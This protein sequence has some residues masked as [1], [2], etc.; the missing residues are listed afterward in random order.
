MRRH[1][2]T[3]FGALLI[4]FVNGASGAGQEP[5]GLLT[6]ND[7]LHYAELNNAGLKSSFQRWQAAKEEIP[8]AKTLPDPQIS[9]NY[10]TKQSDLQ[11]KQTFSVMQPFPWFGKINAR[12]EAATKEAAAAQQNYQA[13]RLALFKE[14]KEGFYE[15]AYLAR[16]IDIATEN[17]E[18]FKHF[19]E[20]ART[21]HM[22]TETG[23]PDVIRAQVEIAKMED[24]LRGLNQLRE[25]TVSR[26]RTALTLPAETN[27]PWPRSEDFNVAEIDY[28]QLVNLLRQKNPEL[29]G[30]NFEAMAA[31]SKITLAEKNLYPDIGIGVMWENMD[32]PGGKD[33]I[34]MVFQM[35]LPLWRDGYTAGQRQ[36]QAQKASIEQQKV[37]TENVLLT[38]ASQAHYEYRDSIRKMRLY[39]DTLIP[40][41]K[42]LLQASEAAYRG[43]TID[44]LSL[45]DAQRMLLDY[46]LS[47]ERAL[48]NNRQK[49]AELE[50]LVG[51]E[52]DSK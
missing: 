4:L 43:G 11:M 27:L 51:A 23:H 15:F 3:A 35:N 1:I 25:P 29:A 50:M 14:V 46:H 33:G 41:G 26:L 30:L 36:A 45:I 28:E 10:W 42:E 38:K 48:A 6:L 52:L 20:V 37:D 49:L 47:Y 21:R 16:A 7:Y 2:K 40:K 34:A 31:K 8:Q 12:T 44:F 17:L 18:L 5:N 32:S 19:E 24:V 39:R 22:T 13:A 9:Y